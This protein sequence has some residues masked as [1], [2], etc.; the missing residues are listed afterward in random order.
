MKCPD[1]QQYSLTYDLERN[2]WWCH[3]YNGFI[4]DE[5]MPHPRNP[6]VVALNRMT[7]AGVMA[8]AEFRKA[9]T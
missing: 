6:L 4:P 7:R 2:G 9:F 8:A 3:V 1:C 5:H